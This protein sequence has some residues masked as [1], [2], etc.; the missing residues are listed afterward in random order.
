M[1]TLYN[2]GDMVVDGVLTTG[3]ALSRDEL[4]PAGIERF[5]AKVDRDVVGDAC[6]L[7]TGE[8]TSNGYGR[9]D[10][11]GR[12]R[13]RAHKVAYALAFGF[14]P[15]GLVV[16]HK[17][18]TPLCCR[19]GHLTIGTQLQN[20]RDCVERGRQA[21]GEAAG[22]AKLTVDIVNDM[23]RRARRGASYA[24]LAREY[25]VV[26]GRVHDACTGVTWK[27]AAEPPVN[28]VRRLK[29]P[30]T[31]GE[32]AFVLRT[33]DVPEKMVAASLGRSRRS[34]TSR[35]YTLRRRQAVAA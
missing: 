27:C 5:E 29:R 13:V 33:L 32:D 23:R 2:L 20:M 19:P 11:G 18:D 4:T 12:R 30:W 8:R 6:H 28:E 3:R 7:W 9:F 31:A 35:R 10:T 22:N 1:D 25:G 14:V 24:D 16:R 34:V 21:Q 15:A 17:C 26:I